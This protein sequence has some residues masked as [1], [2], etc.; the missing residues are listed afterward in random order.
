MYNYI[1]NPHT[2]KLVNINS[3]SGRKILKNYIKVVLGAG[4]KTRNITLGTIDSEVI[5]PKNINKK[6]P[7]QFPQK[8]NDNFLKLKLRVENNGKDMK[9]CPDV[10]FGRVCQWQD[11]CLKVS[12]I[13][14]K[15]F[16]RKVF[17]QFNIGD[18]VTYEGKIG[19]IVLSDDTN[20]TIQIKGE[21][22]ATEHNQI[23]VDKNNENIYPVEK[24]YI[25]SVETMNGKYKYN[26]NVFKKRYLDE[27]AMEKFL[28]S[29]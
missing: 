4:E 17:K 18:E 10:S 12:K 5:V 21:D 13:E 15:K 24:G 9:I 20:Y 19:E 26:L 2:N 28:E 8:F 6:N 29:L 23:K 14:R 22:E 11:N 3:K 1:L 27:N 7:E 25:L 16:G